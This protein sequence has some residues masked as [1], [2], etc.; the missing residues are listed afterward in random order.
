MASTQMARSATLSHPSRTRGILLDTMQ[1]VEPRK[2]APVPNHLLES[3][4]YTKV[5][6]N[7]VVQARPAVVHFGGFELGKTHRQIVQIANISTEVLRMHIIPPQTSYFYIKYTKGDRLVPGLTLDCVIEFTPEEWRYYYDC[8]RIHTPGEENLVIPIHAYP[9]MNTTEWPEHITFPP[10]P[11]GHTSTK[12]IP[13]HCY[14]PIDFEF[15]LSVLQHH[16]AF[17]IKP[18]SG[19][20][21]ANGEVDIEVTFTPSEF[22]TATMKV[23]LKISQFNAKPLVCSI[24]G[25]SLPGLAKQLTM[26]VTEETGEENRVM[27]PLDRARSNKKKQFNKSA[28]KSRKS[29]APST[30][31]DEVEYAGIRFPTNLDTPYAVAQVLAQE[32]GKLR[33]KDLRDAIDAK[34]GKSVAQTRQMKEAM[35]E[36][37]VRQ[38]VYEERQN[39]LRWQVKLGE[40]QIKQ[41]VREEILENRENSWHEYRLKRGD[42]VES[43]EYLRNCTKNTFRRTRRDYQEVALESARFDPYTND[44]WAVRHAALSL[45]QQAAWKIVLR[46]RAERKLA[47]LREMVLN[48]G[49]QGFAFTDN[50]ELSEK[51]KAEEDELETLDDH[52]LT[53]ERIASVTFPTYS[54]PNVKDDMAVDALGPVPYQPTQ[55]IVKYKVPYMSLKVPQQ[56]KLLGYQP[57]N[58]HNASMSYVPPTLMRTLRTGADDEIVNIAPVTTVPTAKIDKSIPTGNLSV[59]DEK[60]DAPKPVVEIKPVSLRPPQALFQPIDY[61][62]LH[63]F[64]PAPG[65]QVFQPPMA[66]G[67]TDPDF[68]LC[69][70]PR[71]ISNNADNTHMATQKQYL[72]REDVIRG[73]MA[74]KRFPSQGLTSLANTPT[75]G[76][77]WVPRWNDD[78]FSHDMLP[79]DTPELQQQ[80]SQSDAEDIDDEDK[81]SDVALTPDMVCAQFHLIDSPST[82][83]EGEQ[84]TKPRDTDMF[85]YGNRMPPTNIPVSNTG[86]VARQKREEELEY[87]MKKKYNRLGSKFQGRIVHVNTLKTNPDLVLK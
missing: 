39:Q 42:P 67:E 51:D 12:V 35:F 26:A 61:P 23:Q 65:L 59:I 8:I 36:M 55:V 27:S 21:P 10:V 41:E 78:V 52:I 34:K 68:H 69:P 75:L 4:I 83:Q 58:V 25:S 22:S 76:S 49:K 18:M 79:S 46:N 40:D 6:L 15:A 5:A 81:C 87:F 45:F 57:H 60:N 50:A 17:K 86:P 71:Y 16:P 30:Y 73:V 77:V 62:P 24:S 38:D 48:W 63:I 2:Y 47:S 56:Y 82:S 84:R 20:V 44:L 64:N 3:K 29:T 32:P 14:A 74:W 85:P 80:L 43:K 33:I 9:V 54:P 37:A 53:G 19:V 70:L 72:D 7:S 1:I 11:V 13:L 66:Y 31:T 28:T